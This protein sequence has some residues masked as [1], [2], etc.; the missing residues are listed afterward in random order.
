MRRSPCPAIALTLVLASTHFVNAQTPPKEFVK[1]PGMRV[2][3]TVVRD[4]NGITNI[5]AANS[6]DLFYLQGY[7]QATDRLFQMDTFRRQ[8]SGT[9]A[10]LLGSAALSSDVQ[11]RTLGLRRAAVRSLAVTSSDGLDALTA[12]A[13]GVNQW[14]ST[15]TLPPEYGALSLTKFEPWTPLDS[16]TIAKL[17]ALNLSFDDDTSNTVAFL[18]YV[19]AG[20]AA[21]FDGT[22]LF[23][24]DLWRV[25]P[26]DPFTTLSPP[27]P[28]RRDSSASFDAAWPAERLDAV[29]KAADEMLANGTL[30]LA[31]AY[32]AKAREIPLLRQTMDGEH[33]LGSNDWAVTGS[34]STT[35]VPLLANDPHLS[36]S[37][38]AIWY[39]MSLR[40][41]KFNVTGNSFAGTP[42]I[43][44]G[45]NEKVAWGSTVNPMDVTDWYSEKI[46][47][48]PGTASGLATVYKGNAE[49]IIAIPEVF[50]MN[51]PG[52]ATKDNITVVPPGGSIPPATLVVPRRDNGPIV[53][54]DATKGTAI[55]VQYTGWSKTRELD[56]FLLFD[57]AK[58]VGEFKD[59]LRYFDVGSQNF[60]VVDT[61]GNIAY[62]T[63]AEMPIREDL[64]ANTVTTPPWLIRDGTGGNEWMPPF[65]LPTEDQAVPHLTLPYSEMPQAV[66]PAQGW[67]ANGNNDPVGT[68]VGN[69]PFGRQ[70]PGGGIYYLRGIG[71]DG[72]RGARIAQVIRKKLEVNGK[73]S[74]ADFKEIQS[75]NVLIDAQV[76][77]PYITQAF[78]NSQITGA[79]P[80]LA[81]LGNN[82]AVAAAVSRLAAWDFTTPTGLKEGWDAGKPA[83]TD[84]T[85][86]QVKASNA[87]TIF[88]AWRG[89]CIANTID[90]AL[91]PGNLPTPGSAL[92]V[93]A[94]RNMLDRF[95]AQG[96]V[97]TS[98]VNFFNVAGV[99]RAEDRRDVILLKSLADALT[100]LSGDAFA[101]AFAKSTNPDD[102]VWG[103]LHR[104][105]FAHPMGDTFSIPSAGGAWP[106]PLGATLPGI[107]RQGGMGTVDA[108]AHSSRAN[109]L[110]GF[111]FSSGPSRR[112]VGEA[113]P[114]GLVAENSLPGGVSGVLGSPYYFNL[115]PMWLTNQTYPLV[116]QT[117][118]AVLSAG[119]VA[120]EVTWRSQYS[121]A[122]GYAR[123]VPEN[124]TTS[125]FYFTSP[126]NPEVFV[127][128]LD[129]GPGNPYVVF[130]AG[131]T[132][133]E[134]T[135]TFTNLSTGKQL[136]YNKPANSYAGGADKS[137]LPQQV[138][139]AA[140]WS[141]D[142]EWSQPL[143]GARSILLERAPRHGA[144]AATGA[145]A[146]N[147]TDG[148][149]GSG[150]ETPLAAGE[151]ALSEGRV[152]VSATFRN[153][154]NG[155]TGAAN[156]VPRKDAFGY[157]S[158]SDPASYE[159]FV[160]VLDFGASNPYV[161]FWAGLTDYEYT[162]SFRN[163]A[164][165]K[166]VQYKKDA[167]SFNGG[168]D[169]TSLPH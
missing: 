75:D 29:R 122:T 44:H 31:L 127:K 124:D 98:G 93:S 96:G 69:N 121:G 17:F 158:F 156:P 77:V 74:R 1:L 71:Y 8:A 164:T 16:V 149:E 59:A 52:T 101:P 50:K 113:T 92:A 83:G 38:A 15:H 40:G 13:A 19:A 81:A 114:A 70:R 6:W 151:L 18:T 144:E 20:K 47:A 89:Q 21:G 61:S 4:A 45:H 152:A 139:Q 132:N 95:G 135:V 48:A 76:F 36:L 126:E 10:E 49:E 2:G 68:T 100:L 35:G 3:G 118:Q 97:G 159:V 142:G 27:A 123:S 147:T 120:V 30:E 56:A 102:Y 133:Y 131:L 161:L 26:F 42:F 129:F 5:W 105:V 153:Q 130:Y 86:A 116:V 112:Y 134:Y 108:A 66:N 103:K 169:N 72:F 165:G 84:P 168:A 94:L 125:Y 23:F 54:L 58:D 82:A 37:T 140:Y 99:A 79:D 7:A 12:Y 14:V 137:G 138:A 55:S 104:I 64:Q 25:A 160:K 109:S 28:P 60:A 85:A 65:G 128:V 157:F 146:G 136:I 41:G 9:L 33:A 141:R 115:L 63:S 46:V 34:L 106:H 11:L 57:L 155:Q 78:T 24:E 162:V 167:G 51:T 91:K 73:L 145:V 87:A 163:V 110:N 111:M 67:F 166:T 39:P 150:Q 119:R 148:T 80:T 53:Q 43:I 88:A 117:E 90:A 143:A 107:P 62:L 22:K 32:Q 154:Y